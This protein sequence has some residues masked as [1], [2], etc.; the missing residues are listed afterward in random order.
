M[1]KCMHACIHVGMYTHMY[2]H[3]YEGEVD[4]DGA[5]QATGRGLI[6]KTK[7]TLLYC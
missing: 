2:A 6:V 3:L 7:R 5:R 4:S 1:H